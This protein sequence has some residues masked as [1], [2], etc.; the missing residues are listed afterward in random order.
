LYVSQ[1]T[2]SA[3]VAIDSGTPVIANLAASSSACTPVSGVGR[4][5]A[6]NVTAQPGTHTF[7]VTLYASTNGT[8][9]ALSQNTISAKITAGTANVV[10]ITL[11]GIVA[12]IAV[13][14]ANPNPPVGAA[15]TTKLTVN[16][17][18]ASGAAIVGNDPFTNPITLTDSDTS[19]TTAI[20]TSG[21]PLKTALNS[22]ADAANLTLSYT[23]AALSQAIISATATGVTPANITAAT[24]AP[25]TSTSSTALVDW[26]TYAYDA[27][28]S[29]YNPYTTGITPA[30]IANF[31]V[32]W[33]KVLSHSTQTQ[34]IVVTNV[35]GHQ[36]LIIIAAFALAQAYDAL[37]GALVWQQTLPGQDVQD[38]GPGPISGTA[39]YDKALGAVFMAAGSGNPAPN[40]V[41]LY[42]LDVATGNITGQ[43]DVTPTLLPG[44]ANFAH[45]GITLANNRVYLGTGSD[46][47]GTP[48]GKYTSWR[49]RVVAVDPNSMT[50]LNTFYTTWNHGGNYGGG[51]VW[52]W[53]GV[54]SDANGNVFV[55]AGNGET[56]GAVLPQTVNPPF[57]AMPEETDGYAQHLTELSP[58]LSTVENSNYP[59]FNYTIGYGDL[60]YTGTPVVFQ[61]TLGSGC[62]ELI[63]TQGKGGTLVINNQQ[64]F[65]VLNS[66]ELSV[67]SGTAYY[68][69]N[70][71]YSPQTGYLY[72]A[73][74][75]SG[76]GS[77]LL[78]PG[79]AAIDACNS[80]IVWNRPF[81]PD[82]LQYGPLTQRSAPTVTA[83][84]VVF[85]A[86][87]CTD[88]GKGGCGTPGTAI[89]GALWAVD[90]K[91]STL[92]STP[93]NPGNPLLVTGD[94][95]RMA[96]SADGLWVYLLDGSGNLYGLTVDPSVPATAL[97]RA[98]HVTRPFHFH[99]SN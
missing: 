6:V 15:A 30:S 72:A 18:D 3:A 55:G 86:T 87:P 5:C 90:A 14:L 54:S 94:F 56:T 57:V 93:N 36:A 44:E 62:G 13:A 43:V 20:L 25:Q 97:K 84:G 89:N 32:A 63:A 76:P 21:A 81:G 83:G 49:G 82:A 71:A 2:Q 16:F 35:A 85:L 98:A 53:G 52:G 60:D 39:Q 19:G 78:P 37:T 88:N 73:V 12:Q 75:S 79:L 61:P 40:H 59:G 31:H 80:K 68:I 47:E 33:Q 7:G 41:V 77:S 91:T 29:G 99:Q 1:N 38:C 34:P 74:T 96:P 17:N 66:F 26:P 4:T 23:G 24:L 8:G 50:L 58:D 92:L 48:T 64:S 51:G 10:S 9:A 28:R 42:R 69:G 45:T 22:P 95:I 11:D 27:Q 65:A 70:P 67:P 46:C